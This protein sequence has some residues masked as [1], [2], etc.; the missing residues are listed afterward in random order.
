MRLV[1][2]RQGT[3]Y[4]VSA[5]ALYL[6]AFPDYERIPVENLHRF[7]GTDLAEYYAIEEDGFR[8][9]AYTVTHGDIFFLLYLAIVP[10]SRGN[11]C[12]GRALDIIKSMAGGRKVFLN[13]EPV[14]LAAVAA[15]TIEQ[16]RM[17]AGKMHVSLELDA[18]PATVNADRQMMEELLYN[19]IDNAIR[20]NVRGGSVRVEV[21]PLR[22]QI[23][24]T[25]Q[26]T[27][28]GIS[29]ENQ[30]HVFERF[31]RVDKSRSKATGGTGL[32][33][34]IVKH[35][36]AKHGAQI[37]MDSELGRGTSISV[38]FDK[39]NRGK[40]HASVSRCRLR[41]RALRRG[42][43]SHGRRAGALP[44]R[45]AGGRRGLHRARGAGQADG[46]GGL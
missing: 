27:G 31:Y 37:V 33:L 19:L 41:P 1:P 12:G 25:V 4:G 5:D 45:S 11:G 39:M 13:M 23:I 32:G 28:I 8:G 18:R 29:K 14:D 36:A 21:R 24:V 46:L 42:R 30:E 34:A 22:E 44:P 26:D 35:I 17:S 38:T 3:Q 10:S 2:V 40:G 15:A 16:L 7:A 20:Y 9:L 6:G 43:H